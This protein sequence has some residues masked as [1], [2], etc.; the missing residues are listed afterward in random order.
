[1]DPSG[2]INDVKARLQR[3][4]ESRAIYLAAK[5]TML[6]VSQRV[7]GRG[8]LTG[9][10]ALGYNE[11]YDLYA[12]TPPAPRKVSGKGKPYADWKYPPKTKSGSV[13]AGAA[14]IKGGYYTSYLSFKKQQGRDD[15]PFELTGRLRKAYFGG[16]DIPEPTQDSETEVTIRLRG[17]EAQKFEG[18]TDSKGVFLGLTASE[19]AE[20]HRRVREIYAET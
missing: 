8:E 18:L 3:L 19:K 17:E 5:G 20:H 9:G 6:D 1:M 10:G 16:G 7:W 15:T 13:R 4:K 2:A 14:N 11:D 12:Y